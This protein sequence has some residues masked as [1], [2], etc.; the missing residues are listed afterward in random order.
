MVFVADQ[1]KLL[2]IAGAVGAKVAQKRIAAL[3][4]ESAE[5][6]ALMDRVEKLYEVLKSQ[7]C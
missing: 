1:K 6:K 4:L 7:K 3:K 5:E 2:K